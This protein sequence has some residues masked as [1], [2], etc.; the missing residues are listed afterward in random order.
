MSW[1]SHS[2]PP[3]FPCLPILYSYILTIASSLKSVLAATSSIA[4]LLYYVVFTWQLC[5][6]VAYALHIA[7]L[8]CL[9][10]AFAISSVRVLVATSSTSAL[11]L[12]WK[13][14]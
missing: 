4:A 9:Y 6:G 2:Q 11:H 3:F 7:T 13:V 10:L 14:A 12:K 5:L 1:W 8:C